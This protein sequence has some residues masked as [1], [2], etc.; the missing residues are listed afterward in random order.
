MGPDLE[1]QGNLK[2]AMEFSVSKDNVIAP[3]GSEDK[4]LH[5]AS[6]CEDKTFGLEESLVERAVEQDEIENMEL[7][8]T[9]II[10]TTDAVLVEGECQDVTEYSSSFGDTDS[11]TENGLML[12]DDEIEPQFGASNSSVYDGC[13][14]TFRIR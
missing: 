2:A 3:E 11:G 1:L 9:D 14:D 6:N 10:D 12:T 7:N 13:F 5:C 8:I 4:L